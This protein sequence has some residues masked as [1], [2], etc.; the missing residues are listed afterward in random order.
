MRKE[1]RFTEEEQQAIQTVRD[2]FMAHW[3]ECSAQFDDTYEAL[4][5][6]YFSTDTLYDMIIDGN[7][8]LL[9]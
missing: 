2:I 5:E 7:G 6:A 3:D 8:I 4:K 1:I 9:Q